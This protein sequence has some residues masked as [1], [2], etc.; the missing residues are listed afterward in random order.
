LWEGHK[1][2]HLFLKD[3]R[4]LMVAGREGATFFSGVATEK[5]PRLQ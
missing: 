5:I 2:L 3:R 4:K 1:R